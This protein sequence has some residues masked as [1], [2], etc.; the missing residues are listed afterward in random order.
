MSTLQSVIDYAREE[1]CQDSSSKEWGSSRMVRHA[2]S[3]HRWL[4][5]RMARVR[6]SRWFTTSELITVSAE[7]FDLNTLTDE[8]AAVRSLFHVKTTG[9]EIKMEPGSE[10]EENFGRGIN[11]TSSNSTP[12]Y[13]IQQRTAADR[14]LHVLPVATRT[15]RILYVHKPPIL[16]GGGSL[17]T[18][19][20]YDDLLAAEIARRAIAAEG[21]ADDELTA[22]VQQ[23]LT[24]VMED[25]HGDGGETSARTIRDAYGGGW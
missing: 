23:R 18:P 1:W 11:A 16:T 17:L 4:A 24:D 21:E 15:L 7:T 6:G 12:N 5:R 19:D 3:A 8:F 25:I 13:Y 22:F 10:G 14:K 20:E 9:S 2:N